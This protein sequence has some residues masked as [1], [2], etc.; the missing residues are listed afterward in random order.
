MSGIGACRL[1]ILLDKEEKMI[2]EITSKNITISPSS[3]KLIENY[4]H[5]LG[6]YFR[7]IY[8]IRWIFKVFKNGIQAWLQ[9]HSH[10]GDYSAHVSGATIRSVLVAAG[11]R[12]EKQRRRQKRIS[13]RSQ[14]HLSDRTKR[15]L[16]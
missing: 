1:I 14:R 7:R 9:I 4:N 11:E 3:R 10:S 5:R 8:S 15:R 16:E 12:I 6:R 2:M 13:A